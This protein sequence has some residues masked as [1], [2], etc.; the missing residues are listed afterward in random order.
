MQAF[1]VAIFEGVRRGV[2]IVQG[3]PGIVRCWA[4][5]L[6]GRLL[7][8]RL[9]LVGGLPLRVRGLAGAVGG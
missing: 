2:E 3:W 6:A 8:L 5:G 4:G 1:D 9:L 7:E